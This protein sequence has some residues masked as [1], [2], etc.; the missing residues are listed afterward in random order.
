[1][2]LAKTKQHINRRTG[3]KEILKDKSSEALPLAKLPMNSTNMSDAGK[4]L[5]YRKK[6]VKV[7]GSRSS[8][9]MMDPG[10]V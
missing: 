2:E 4:Y 6:W 7:Q 5:L 9:S 10:L 1:M 8:S 3:A